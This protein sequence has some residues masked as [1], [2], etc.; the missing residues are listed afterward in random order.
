MKDSKN[1]L[2]PREIETLCQQYIECKLSVT[3][4]NEL[5]YLLYHTD[6]RSPLIDETRQ[7]MSISHSLKFDDVHT[8]IGNTRRFN[9]LWYGAA[10]CIAISVGCFFMLNNQVTQ[11]ESSSYLCIAYVSGQELTGSEAENI[12][13]AD[14]A[15]MQRFMQTVD[16]KKTE[17][18]TKVTQFM[19]HN[20]LSK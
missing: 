10:A 17:E 12:A 6:I 18:E 11:P 19:N 16:A 4:E 1:I 9:R 2:T 14:I 3:E 8:T 15:K 7:L 20:T 13:N 5:E